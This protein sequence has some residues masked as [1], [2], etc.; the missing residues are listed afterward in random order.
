MM[1]PLISYLWC[2]LFLWPHLR[3]R[4]DT[5]PVRPRPLARPIALQWSGV[6]Q[7]SRRTFAVR[8]QFVAL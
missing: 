6:A 1:L 4:Y 3:R 2:L 7:L 5:P 8:V